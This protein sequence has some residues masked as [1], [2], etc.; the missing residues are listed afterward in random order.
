MITKM[1]VKVPIVTIFLL[2]LT[3]V[4]TVLVAGEGHRDGKGKFMSFFDTNSDG[5]VNMAEF[6]KAAADRFLKMDGDA[7]GFVTRDEF[8]HYVT[9]RRKERRAK[10]FKKIDE[11]GDGILSQQ[12]YINYKVK[13]AESRFAK[14]DGNADGIVSVEEF[15]NRKRE[16]WWDKKHRRGK[17]GF[18][19]KL[20]QNGDGRITQEESLKAW[21][22]WFKRMDTDGNQVVTSDEVQAFRKSMRKN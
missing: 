4:S 19:D 13:K 14:M 6:K 20:D 10:W 2:T 22:G 8:R 9:E 21:T 16:R 1:N 5:T 18:F 12:E 17:G 7:N 15:K 11:N 3:A